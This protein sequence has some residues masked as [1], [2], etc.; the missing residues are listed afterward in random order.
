MI[1]RG[2]PTPGQD[3]LDLDLGRVAVAQRRAAWRQWVAET[4]G[5]IEVAGCPEGTISGF[6]RGVRLGGGRLL[7]IRTAGREITCT[8]APRGAPSLTIMLQRS[9]YCSFEQGA[10]RGELRSGD[11]CV[12]NNQMPFRQ[13]VALGSEVMLL[14]TGWRPA[15]TRHA[16]LLERSGSACPAD[17]PVAALVRGAI[18]S[19]MPTALRLP[20]HRRE[21]LCLALFD[22]AALLFDDRAS[23]AH[24][25][26]RRQQVLTEIDRH[27]GDSTFDATRLAAAIGVS[28]RRLDQICVREFG[29]A[30]A[31]C[32]RQRRLEHAREL[33]ADPRFDGCTI[34]EIALDAGFEDM[35]HFTRIFKARHGLLPSAARRRGAAPDDQ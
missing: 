1:E 21:A 25:H 2:L 3:V 27:L 16:A 35:S 29:C 22:L 20:A 19:A 17:E 7:H 5:R 9:G 10:R 31:T 18:E 26:H 34:T 12:L 33:L 11:I 6:I 15:T 24:S 4:F 23:V 28:R 8:D 13:H 14:Q 32:L 30:A